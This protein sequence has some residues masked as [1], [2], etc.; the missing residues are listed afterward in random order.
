M[1]DGR[2]LMGRIHV[3]VRDAAGTGSLFEL[4]GGRG[5]IEIEGLDMRHNTC[6]C[7][8]GEVFLE[9]WNPRISRLVTRYSS[10]QSSQ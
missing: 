3:F 6:D 2:V 1:P 4:Q 9:V 10:A 7:T 8:T 5:M